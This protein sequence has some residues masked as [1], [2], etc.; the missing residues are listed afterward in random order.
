MIFN[1]KPTKDAKTLEGHGAEYFASASGLKQVNGSNELRT[2]VLEK[3]VS[4]SNGVHEY[5]FS[6]ASYSGNDLPKDGYQ[7]GSATIYKRGSNSIAVVLYG[8]NGTPYPSI[9]YYNG[10]A[11]IG[12]IELNLAKYLPLIGGIVDGDITLASTNAVARRL[13]VKNS[14]RRIDLEVGPDGVG[15]LFDSTNGKAII[16]SSLDGTNAINGTASGN[17]AL[18]GATTQTVKAPAD[19]PMAVDN[20][21]SGASSSYIS[22]KC[23]G[24][25]RGFIGFRN[26]IARVIGADGNDSGIGDILHSGNSAKVHIGTSAP[27]DTTALWI[28]TSA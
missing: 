7:Y 3:A 21:A 10:T 27:S 19:T 4:L 16:Q 17:L 20:A 18:N 14:K 6:G 9:N 25:N 22:F 23:E 13:I 8:T 28:D 15:Y 5:T 26:G 12:W 1:Y 24:E 2:S 11:W